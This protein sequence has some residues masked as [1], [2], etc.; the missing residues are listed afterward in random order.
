MPAPT[1]DTYMYYV[2]KRFSPDKI[3]RM[4]FKR[5][6]GFTQ[7]RGKSGAEGIAKKISEMEEKKGKKRND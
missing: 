4:D 5:K 1:Q 2:A 6:F 7:G 3:G